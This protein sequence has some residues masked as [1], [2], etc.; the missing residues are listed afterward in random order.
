MAVQEGHGK[1]GT[2]RFNLPDTNPAYDF[3]G[4]GRPPGVVLGKTPQLYAS[5]VPGI[6]AAH[7]R[8]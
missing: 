5:V 7:L 2:A 4:P 8:Q 3:V 1:G 6:T